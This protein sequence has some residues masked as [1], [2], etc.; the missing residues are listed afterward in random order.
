ME[1]VSRCPACS[2]LVRPGQD[3]CTLCHADL[4]PPQ[5]EVDELSTPA[6]AGGQDWADGGLEQLPGPADLLLADRPVA[7]VPPVTADPPAVLGKHARHAAPQEPEAQGQQ[8]V[9]FGSQG[10]S[11]VGGVLP[12]AEVSQLLAQLAA[13]SPDP[14]SGVMSRLPESQGMRVLAALAVGGVVA[15]VLVGISW[16]LGLILG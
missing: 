9:P 6:A 10:G 14:L 16:I 7:T 2:S 13:Q 1:Y 8:S 4:R 12:E 3:W 15:S 11:P 5:P